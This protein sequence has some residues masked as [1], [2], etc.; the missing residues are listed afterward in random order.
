MK[1]LLSPQSKKEL[2]LLLKKRYS[3]YSIQ[4]LSTKIGISKK[5]LQGWF[6]K[7][8]RYLPE[9]ILDG[10][11]DKLKIIDRKEDNWGQIKGG[12]KAYHILMKKG[13]NEVRK[14]Q[15]LGGKR[16]AKSK[17]LKAQRNFKLEYTEDFLE[18]YGVLLGDG[19]LSNFKT[20]N[21][22]VWLIGLCGNLF[23]DKDFIYY[24]KNK[25]EILFNRKGFIRE[26]IENNTIEFLFG[27]K[28]L[29]INLN[30]NL[31]FPIGIKENLR[32]PDQ[33]C[34]LGFEKVRYI[35]RGIFDT[36]GSFYLEKN[37]KGVP[38]YPVLSIHMKEPILV[39]QIST[40]L[41]N[42]GFSPIFSNGGNQIK[43]KGR[44]QLKMWVGL[45]GSSN[46]YKLEKM[47]NALVAQPG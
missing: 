11:K 31:G 12:I 37:R 36:D 46:P 1:F 3:S 38:A 35:I 8:K 9:E 25:V 40:F 24:W 16:A 29:L 5:T 13:I 19:W 44:K 20:A 42:E 45:I 2:F 39:K 27:H 23:H 30:R 18:F 17:E 47:M 32:I 7:R 41:F 22:K 4:E 10:F 28:L 26:K 6:Y 14:K 33:F 34:K 15:S 43:L 21:K